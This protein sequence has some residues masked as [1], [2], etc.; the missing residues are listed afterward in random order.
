MKQRPKPI[1]LR[2]IS[3][4]MKLWRLGF[5]ISFVGAVGFGWYT[6]VGKSIGSGVKN[7]RAQITSTIS[8]T[9]KTVT[10]E[11]NPI[12]PA[13]EKAKQ[14]NVQFHQGVSSLKGEVVKE[15]IYQN[16]ASQIKYGK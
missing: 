7:A 8:E 12:A 16:M 5:M 3:R 10:K 4:E 14:L 1:H 13:E 15:E 11:G 9:A 6:T 2:P